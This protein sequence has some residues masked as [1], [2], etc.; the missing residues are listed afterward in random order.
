MDAPNPSQTFD[1]AGLLD[2]LGGDWE[3]LKEIA[4]V[5]LDDCPRLLAEIHKAVLSHDSERLEHAAHALKGAVSNFG[6]ESARRAAF[7]LEELGRAKNLVP[8]A[9]AYSTLEREL[10]QFTQ[11]LARLSRE[12]SSRQANR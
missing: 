8:A 5:F 10:G 9:E 11:E 6:A 2:R 4:G 3:F 1:V 12:L 7:Q